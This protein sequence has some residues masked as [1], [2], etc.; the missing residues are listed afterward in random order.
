M[1]SRMSASAER[2]PHKALIVADVMAVEGYAKYSIAVEEGQTV[3]K[4]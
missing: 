1:V 3:S 2:G 4:I